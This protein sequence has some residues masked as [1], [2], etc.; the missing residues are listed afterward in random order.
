MSLL[1]AGLVIFLGMHSIRI[2][3][4]PTRLQ[5]IERVGEMPY[6]GLYTVISLIGFFL[7]VYGYGEARLTTTPVWNPPMA[8]RHL[9]SLLTLLAFVLLAASYVPGNRIKRALGHPMILSVKVWAIAH[10]LA[11]GTVADIV[12]FGAFLLWA[13]LDFRAA[14]MRDR[15][16]AT[17]PAAV[18]GVSL[19]RDV[20]TVI[21]G[22]IGW[23]V[24]ALWLH[25]WLIGIRPFG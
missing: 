12:L 4:E 24:F 8:M 5:L 15:D 2:F 18:A 16:A 21:A 6:K 11:N 9:A 13:V 14:R 10:L 19:A 20:A 23:V 25:G 1:I 22:V 7:I 17:K 3:A